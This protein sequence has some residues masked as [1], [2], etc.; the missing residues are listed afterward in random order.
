MDLEVTTDPEQMPPPAAVARVYAAAAATA[1]LSSDPSM[2]R[3]FAALYSWARALPGAASVTARDGAELVGF[4]YGYSWD[5]DSMTDPWSHEL[6]ERLGA[7][8]AAMDESFS[9][10]LLAVV[11]QAQRKGLGRK[12]LNALV[13]Q[14]DED[15]AWLQA[16]V[17]DSPARRLYESAGWTELGPGPDSADGVP[18]VVLVHRRRS[19]P[20][21][22]APR[23]HAIGRARTC[24]REAKNP[25]CPE[26]ARAA[27]PAACPRGAKQ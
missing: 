20:A 14:A 17:G 4:G 3:A 9:V 18:S 15:V 22:F 19:D 21:G 23:R 25:P 7:A 5:W 27:R 12:L 8:A 10:V 16:P 26:Q 24:T 6:R 13:D 11:P 1:P 2:A